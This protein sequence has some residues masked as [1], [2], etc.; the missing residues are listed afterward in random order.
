MHAQAADPTAH[1]TFDEL[2]KYL[3]A[4]KNTLYL[5]E[6]KQEKKSK[7]HQPSDNFKTTSKKVK[8]SNNLLQNKEKKPDC[9]ICN[10]NHLLLTVKLF[11]RKHLSKE[12]S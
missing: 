10:S 11:F 1:P 7:A 9:S 5:F 12:N 3:D 8:K 2:S 4:E 6:S